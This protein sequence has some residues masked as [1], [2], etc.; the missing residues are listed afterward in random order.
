MC[1]VSIA[2]N[3]ITCIAVC[4]FCAKHSGFESHAFRTQKQERVSTFVQSSK[5]QTFAKTL[6]FLLKKYL[7][8]LRKK[9]LD[10]GV[11]PLHL[12]LKHGFSE[13]A[14]EYLF[15]EDFLDAFKYKDKGDSEF[16]F[17][18]S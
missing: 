12:A 10:K 3:L 1:R 6:E 16:T 13:G 18:S 14:V 4:I 8:A 9:T 11:T 2:L 5:T 7:L 15:Q 17:F